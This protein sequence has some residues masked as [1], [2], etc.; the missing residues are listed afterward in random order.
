MTTKEQ[1][2]KTVTAFTPIENMIVNSVAYGMGYVCGK[3]NIEVDEAELKKIA[4]A[5]AANQPCSKLDLTDQS[6]EKMAK[7]KFP[8][9][10]TNIPNDGTNNGRLER[11]MKSNDEQRNRQAGYLAAMK[12]IRTLLTQA[13]E[14][15]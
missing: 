9:D 10:F 14:K 3:H 15:I 13:N 2:E 7:T 6:I 12:E 8:V 11:Q 4:K 1:E 5:F